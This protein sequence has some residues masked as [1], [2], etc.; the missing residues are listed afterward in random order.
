MRVTVY[1]DPSEGE[2]RFH[3]EDPKDRSE[4]QH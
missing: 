4:P 1:P 2:A 3:D